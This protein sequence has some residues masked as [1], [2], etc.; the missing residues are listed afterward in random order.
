VILKLFI[1]VVVST[2]YPQCNFNTL[3]IIAIDILQSFKIFIVTVIKIDEDWYPGYHPAWTRK[4]Q[5]GVRY[6]LAHHPKDFRGPCCAPQ[7][8]DN[9]IYKNICKIDK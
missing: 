6:D 5:V 9:Y 1:A 3:N 4:A 2:V 7:G 8:L